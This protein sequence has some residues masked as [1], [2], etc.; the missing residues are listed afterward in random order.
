MSYWVV[1]TRITAKD[2]LSEARTRETLNAMLFFALLVLLLFSFSFQP[3]SDEERR[4]AAGVLWIAVLFAGLSVLDR[5]F[6]RERVNECLDA[7]RLTPAQAS[8]LFLGK[9]VA[10]FLFLLLAEAILIPLF[11]VFFDLSFRG[12]LNAWLPALL[13][14]TW[15]LVINGTFFAAMTT[16]LRSRELLLPLL[17]LPISV[18]ALIAVIEATVVALLGEG[19]LRVWMQMLIAFDLIYTTL[20]LLLFETVLEGT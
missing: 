13:L 6:G 14:G 10:N 12:G 1:A 11:L 20:A 5:S 2:L 15:A 7:L 17:L 3:A 8:A 9:C 18:P 19:T 4:M 16:N